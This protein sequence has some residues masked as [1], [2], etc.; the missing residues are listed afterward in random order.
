MN[1]SK[2]LT[3]AWNIAWKHKVLWLFGILAS[4]GINQRGR[5]GTYSNVG[6]KVNWIELLQYQQQQWTPFY[7]QIK[8]SYEGNGETFLLVVLGIILVGLLLAFIFLALST[9][10]S[11]GLIQA[12]FRA[13]PGIDSISLNKIAEDIM[14]VFWRVFLLNSLFF[15]VYLIYNVIFSGLAVYLLLATF[16]PFGVGFGGLRVVPIML[17][18]GLLFWY[19]SIVIQ[20]ANIVLVAEDLGVG[21]ALRIGWDICLKNLGPV[22]GVGLILSISTWAVGLAISSLQ[23]IITNPI[24]AGVESGTRLKVLDSL[25]DGLGINLVFLGSVILVL[26]G[27]LYSFLQSAWVFTYVELR[28]EKP[29]KLTNSKAAQ[30][31]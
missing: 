6:N 9:F 30:I 16:T 17:L 15:L 24:L 23:S 26:R 1:Y 11:V 27:I 29:S 5:G 12:A 13:V 25:S 22:I 8:Q 14:P 31:P 20:Q 18:L 3:Q 28:K 2:I 19:L 10:G 21:K 4:C 7:D